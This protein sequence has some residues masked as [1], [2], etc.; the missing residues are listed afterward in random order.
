MCG[1]NG[2]SKAQVLAA[3]PTSDLTPLQVIERVFPPATRV[4]IPKDMKSLPPA[5]SSLLA[6]CASRERL[7]F[8]LGV[9]KGRDDRC[10][11]LLLKMYDLD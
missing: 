4:P 6:Y 1:L 9:Y 8:Y 10:E 2:D 7:A 5:L 3:A 11:L